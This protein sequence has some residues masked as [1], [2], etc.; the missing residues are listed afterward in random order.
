MNDATRDARYTKR[1]VERASRRWKHILDVQ[2]PYRWNLRRLGL[3]STLDIGC[4][5][6]RNLA[7]IGQGAVGIDHNSHSIAVARARGL[8]AFTPDE[9]QR[10][11]YCR[12]RAFDSIL[13]AHVAEHMNMD[14]AVA[15]LSSHV[16][17]LRP[18]G[19]AV[20]ICPQEAGFHS[21]ATHVEFMDFD[22][23]RRILQASGFSPVREYSFPFP[24]VVGRFF[25]YNEFVSVGVLQ[26]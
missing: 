15:L 12:D 19:K 25:L 9:F 1:L 5:I 6:G 2:A 8:T 26:S 4:G 24:R 14:E 13:I 11:P 10:S 3:G 21:D 7:H 20:L 18:G 16:R 17:F 23:L 22:K